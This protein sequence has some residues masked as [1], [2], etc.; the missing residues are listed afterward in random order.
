MPEE[1]LKKKSNPN[2]VSLNT[3]CGDCREEI[4]QKNPKKCP[5]CGGTNLVSVKD[6]LSDMLSEIDRLKKSGKYEDAALKY[7]ELEMWD[8]AEEIRKRNV[9]KVSSI[10]VKCPHCGEAKEISAK[11]N[12]IKCKRCAK[13]YTVPKKAL[14]L[15]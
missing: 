12:E 6:A 13:K 1:A 3:R 10:T 5:Y 9:G 15:L 11:N 2:P 8:K 4:L 14:E 7:E